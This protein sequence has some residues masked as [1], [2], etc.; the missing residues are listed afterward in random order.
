M[1]VEMDKVHEREQKSKEVFEA[2]LQR[3]A[4]IDAARTSLGLVDSPGTQGDSAAVETH[5]RNVAGALKAV[6][7]CLFKDF[8]SWTRRF[9]SLAHCRVVWDALP[10][11]ACDTCTPSSQVHKTLIRVLNR[12][13]LNFKEVST[14]SIN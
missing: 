9:K 2:W 7:C 5:W 8:V 11:I 3:K 4:H 6:D 1:Q 13:G 12:P 14:C 10:P